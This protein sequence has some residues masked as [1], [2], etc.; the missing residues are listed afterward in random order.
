MWSPR[1]WILSCFLVVLTVACAT[2]QWN[3]Y[4]GKI[5][6]QG[7]YCRIVPFLKV[8]LT[9]YYT[10]QMQHWRVSRVTNNWTRKHFIPCWTSFCGLIVSRS[11]RAAADDNSWESLTTANVWDYWADQSQWC[12]N[13][14]TRYQDRYIETLPTN[15]MESCALWDW[16]VW[17]K[18]LS[19]SFNFT[20]LWS[21]CQI[22]WL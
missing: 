15:V 6:R 11:Q 7:K 3:P 4:E 20:F 12:L 1:W 5:Q 9:I 8:I 22:H 17:P 2:E 14:Q 16:V 13:E 21:K 10:W 18:V 19:I